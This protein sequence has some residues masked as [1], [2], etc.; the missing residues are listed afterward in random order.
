MEYLGVIEDYMDAIEVAPED[1]QP[2]NKVVEPKKG[3][4]QTKLKFKPEYYGLKINECELEKHN[5]TVLEIIKLFNFTTWVV[6]RDED[7]GKKKIPHY[8]IHFKSSKTLD[9]LQ[10]Q[11]QKVMT[12]WGRSTKIAGPSSDMDNWHCWAGYATKEK[13]IGMSSDISDLDK[14]EIAKHAHTQAVIKKSK[15]DWSNKQDVKK[16]EKNDLE[17]RIFSI[18]DK[19]FLHN[20]T[21]DTIELSGRFGDCYFDE[22]GEMPP[23]TTSKSKIWKWLYTRKKVTMRFYMMNTTDFRYI[24]TI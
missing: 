23:A 18:L 12:R 5:T 14:V 9:A 7:L 16:Q 11:K 20:A 6:G 22:V 19:E 24:G 17:T 1:A 21:I 13:I 8:H 2:A 10:K 4:K 15:L 3:P